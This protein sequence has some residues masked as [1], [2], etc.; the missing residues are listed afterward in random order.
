MR[1]YD[2]GVGLTAGILSLYL[3]VT[4]SVALLFSITI[5]VLAS[6]MAALMSLVVATAGSLSAEHFFDSFHNWRGYLL[7]GKI[8]FLYLAILL[9]SLGLVIAPIITF[10]ATIS[11]RYVLLAIVA[12][13][14]AFMQLVTLDAIASRPEFNSDKNEQ[15]ANNTVNMYPLIKVGAYLYF[16]FC[17]FALTNLGLKKLKIPT[18][19]ST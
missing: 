12:G 11:K 10:F 7:P 13:A 5:F 17:A 19:R 6:F 8:F 15:V 2:I 3:L 1:Y 14:C 9:M 16:G 18:M 4:A